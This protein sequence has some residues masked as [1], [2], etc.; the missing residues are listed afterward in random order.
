MNGFFCQVRRL[1]L[2]TDLESIGNRFVIYA[3]ND[4][5]EMGDLF[6]ERM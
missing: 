6:F 3:A 4:N 5:K 1:N 2:D